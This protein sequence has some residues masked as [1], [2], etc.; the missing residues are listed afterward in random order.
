LALP[1][2]SQQG[3]AAKINQSQV[4]LLQMLR[5]RPPWVSM[6]KMVAKIAII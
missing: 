6:I 5:A 2:L 3:A 4:P 1:A